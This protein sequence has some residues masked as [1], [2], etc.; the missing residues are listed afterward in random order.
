MFA[1]VLPTYIQISLQTTEHRM[2]KQLVG[3]KK[4]LKKTT[5]LS[6]VKKQITKSVALLH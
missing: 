6:N 2:P 4:K 1:L 3:A 5:A